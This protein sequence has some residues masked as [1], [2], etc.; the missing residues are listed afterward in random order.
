MATIRDERFADLVLMCAERT[1]PPMLRPA[2]AALLVL[3]FAFLLAP[4]ADL[5]QATETR[6]LSVNGVKRTY[7]LYLPRDIFNG[8][9]PVVIALHG[10]AQSASEF[11]ADLGMDRV[12][13]RERFA[14][15]YPIGFNR[16]WEDSRPPALRLEFA[17]K[18]GDDVAFLTALVH[19]LVR[20]G[21]ADRTRIYMT[22]LS[23]GGFMTARMACEQA[24]LFAA[25]AVMAATV[26]KKYRT[27]CRPS[28]AMPLL[29]MHGTLDPISSW[30]GVFLPGAELLSAPETAKFF[31]ELGG[32]MTSS[33]Y[34]LPG[35]N[36]AERS[37]VTVRRY[38]LCSENA[39]VALYSIGGGG[40]LPPS[41][42]S[43][44]GES[45]VSN[46]LS[47]RS[48]AIDAAEEIWSFF[49]QF[50][51]EAFPQRGISAQ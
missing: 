19:S 38:S 27:T 37:V 30:Y 6:D 3:A 14:V 51:R 26:P 49:R 13:D 42:D 8:P 23:M 46:F 7:R 15:V 4:A 20:E 22:G 29:L 32:C 5:A 10:A 2:R 40:H 11:E 24:D 36:S 18:P 1:L 25:I 41:F 35:R 28:R 48:H 39:A 47:E 33:D 21:I 9:L 16:V 44:R 43:G 34:A 45:F 17:F 50:R 31:A 12:A